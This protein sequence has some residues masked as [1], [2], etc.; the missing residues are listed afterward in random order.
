MFLTIATF[1]VAF[2]SY[3]SENS[4]SEAEKIAQ[5]YL[6]AFFQGNLKLSF[7]L[8]DQELLQEQQNSLKKE[9]ES[10]I[11]DGTSEQF[12][13]QFNGI[14]DFDELLKLPPSEFFATLT[15]KDRERAGPE[16]LEMMKKSIVKTKNSTFME[17]NQAKVTLEIVTPKP[18]GS[19]F[20]QEGGL[21]LSFKNGNWLVVGNSE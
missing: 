11:K 19:T 6:T 12:V 20:T 3:P 18:D 21:V 14:D 10:S 1:V 13:Q 7:S 16:S 2:N 15:E 4:L 9:Y 8:M 17:D 5:T